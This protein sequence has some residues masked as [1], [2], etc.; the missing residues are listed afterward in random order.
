MS[1]AKKID[2]RSRTIREILGSAKYTIDYYQR[3]YK[4]QQEHV[5]TL[6]DDLDSKFWDS[7]EQ[8]KDKGREHVLSYPH[9]FLGSFV[10]S[11]KGSK[12]AIIDGQQRLTSITL[13]LLYIRNLAK[14]EGIKITAIDNLIYSEQVGKM[15]FNIEVAER[16]DCMERLFNGSEPNQSDVNPS[17]RNIYERNA[18][19]EELFPERLKGDVLP[20]FVDWFIECVDMVEITAFTDD[21]AYTIFETMNDRGLRLTAADMLKGYLLSNIQ[22]DEKRNRANEQWREYMRVLIE[23]DKSEDD[24][25]LKKWLRAKFADSIRERKKGASNEDFEKIGSAFHKWVREEKDRLGLQR[26]EDCYDFITDKMGFFVPLYLRLWKAENIF[27]PALPTVFY[28]RYHYFTHQD[29]LVLSAVRLH[30]SE[31]EIRRKM[32]LISRFA[33]MYIVLRSINYKTLSSSAI[34]Y[35][36]FLL[37]KDVR[38]KS[39][40]E[41]A[42]VLKKK[43]AEMAQEK[44]TFAG[45]K[46]F[47]MHQQN[48]R[49][50]KFLL[51]RITQHIEERSGESRTVEQYMSDEQKKPFEIEHVLANKYERHQ[52]EFESEDDFQEWRNSIGALVLLPRGYNQS[53]NDDEYMAK[54][55]HYLSQNLLARSLHQ[56]CYEKNPSFRSYMEET[57]MLF[58]SYETFGKQAIKERCEL[59]QRICEEIWDVEEFDRIAAS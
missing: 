26:G 18:D 5:A 47:V 8:L 32:L 34:V 16:A 52:G 39:A 59:L 17:V 20:F 29:P 19:L 44:Q 37:T 51:A 23:Q 30:D 28:T 46:D 54:V 38:D 13:L 25:F 12:R 6:L 4:W 53:F 42:D 3:E 7:Y 27:D 21:D 9:Y 2:G 22:D 11:A 43:I 1:E 10:L 36:M 15:S 50:V 49:F 35:G 40:L 48:K 55:K 31:E 41:L 56:Q 14:R 58:K 57:G 45:V 24:E 33:E